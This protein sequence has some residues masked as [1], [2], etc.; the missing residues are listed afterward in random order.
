MFGIG[1]IS[2]WSVNLLGSNIHVNKNTEALL[3]SNKELG[4]EVNAEKTKVIDLTCIH[5]SS[6]D[7]RKNSKITNPSKM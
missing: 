2:L 4:L 6:P 1:L 7:Y 3:D 5:V